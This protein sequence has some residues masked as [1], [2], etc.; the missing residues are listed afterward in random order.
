ML[1]AMLY[2]FWLKD[3]EMDEICVMLSCAIAVHCNSGR[4][5][6]DLNLSCKCRFCTF[7]FVA[8]I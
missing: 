7:K 8:I 4:K 1:A 6:N 2:C 5:P 3:M